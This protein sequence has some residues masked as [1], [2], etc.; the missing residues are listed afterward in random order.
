[1]DIAAITALIG[2]VKTASELAKAIK[3]S[4]STLEQAEV[5]LKL[6]DL[7][8]TLADVRLEA[9]GVQEELLAAREQI[10]SLESAAKQRA[11]IVWRQ[12]CYWLPRDG[13]VSIEEPYCQPCHDNDQRLS[14]LHHDSRGAFTCMVCK[15]IFR[16]DARIAAD[17]EAF[18][19]ANARRRAARAGSM[20]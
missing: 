17:S 15:T 20:Y 11:S 6:A 12:P 13:D 19:A 14:R 3:D 1:M 4:G 18:K 9:A 10:R 5:K 8:S 2:G 7:I 16:T